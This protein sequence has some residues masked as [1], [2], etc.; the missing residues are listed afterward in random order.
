MQKNL[1]LLSL[2][3]LNSCQAQLPEARDDFVRVPNLAIDYTSLFSVQPP[4]P[5]EFSHLTYEAP[6][7]GFPVEGIPRTLVVRKPAFVL[8]AFG[9]YLMGGNRGEW[10]GEL[11]FRGP[12]GKIEVLL[13]K[14]IEGIFSMPVGVLAFSGLAHMSYNEGAIYLVKVGSDG[15]ISASL[16]RSL[17]GAPLDVS[18]TDKGDLVFRVF[19]GRFEKK[20]GISHTVLDCYLLDTA[21]GINSIPCKSIVKA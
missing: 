2:L 18:R 6:S 14:N 4:L 13:E 17:P 19:S 7:P 20:D 9:G 5:V 1:A 12:D 10:G 15:H 8:A 21:G 11:V 16:W 3:L